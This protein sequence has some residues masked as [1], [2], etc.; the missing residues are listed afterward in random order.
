MEFLISLGSSLGGVIGG[1]LITHCYHKKTQKEQHKQR[2]I[3]KLESL[4]KDI[5]FAYKTKDK[6]KR[7]E[8]LQTILYIS[9]QNQRALLRD[10]VMELGDILFK[11][12]DNQDQTIVEINQVFRKHFPKYFN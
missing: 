6:K 4:Q 2:I 11:N 9:V 12:L 7:K 5:V 3:D 10:S 8:N 1:W